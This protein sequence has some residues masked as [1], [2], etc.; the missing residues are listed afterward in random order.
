MNQLANYC[1]ALFASEGTSLYRFCNIHNLERTSIRRLLNGE[2]LPREEVFEEFANAL[3]LT[4]KESK[5]L[6]ELYLRQKLGPLRYENRIF[7]KEF[8]DY[9][10]I[11]HNFKFSKNDIS[12]HYTFSLEDTTV[13]INNPLELSYIFHHLFLMEDT[14]IYS[15]I[16]ADKPLFFQLIQQD[17]YDQKRTIPFYHILTLLKKSD[18]THNVNYNLNILKNII[19]FAFQHHL[20]YQPFYSYGN[21]VNENILL[22][23]PFYVLTSN[24]ILLISA[25]CK[26][27]VL[28]KDETLKN[29]YYKQCQI[30]MK[31]SRP[32]IYHSSNPTQILEY[33]H[34]ALDTPSHPL[35]TF[36]FFPCLFKI[37]SDE[38]FIPQLTKNFQKNRELIQ[39]VQSL[40]IANTT[41]PPYEAFL[42]YEGL[43]HF[44]KTGELSKSL[45]HI[46]NPFPVKQRKVI[47]ETIKNDCSDQSYHLHI[48][49]KNYFYSIPEIN[50][51]IFSDH[52]MNILSMNKENLFSFIYLKENSIYDSFLDYFESLLE[53]PN[54]SSVE[55]SVQ[56]IQEI[57]DEYLA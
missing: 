24:Y 36:D 31:Q 21:P 5:K 44:A 55:E 16:P 23:Y 22:P 34:S 15:N 57:M 20:N 27:G 8:F 48:F 49:P 40:S 2:Y 54:V 1:N 42:P 11:N 39:V 50:L 47:L 43:V 35:Y 46:L 53:D 3:T 4:P 25:N 51:E 56:I 12:S 6:H 14:N 17:F 52:R 30:M 29:A 18:I 32:F 9:I 45:R 7:I 41:Y 10:G 33:W 19:P 37:Y 13:E 38:L 28:S 26:Q